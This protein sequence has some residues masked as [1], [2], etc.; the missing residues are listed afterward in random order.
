MEQYTK[1]LADTLYTGEERNDRT[2]VGTIGTFSRSLSFDLRDGYPLVTTKKV[3]YRAVFAEL[4]GFIE[5][6]TS[7]ARFRE[8]GTKIWDQN[9]NENEAWLSNPYRRGTDDLGP[10]YGAQ[11]RNWIANDD[12]RTYSVIDQ[13]QNLIDG[14]LADPYDRAHIVS[15]WNPAVHDR[16]ALRPCHVMFQCYVGNE[17]F[18]DMA[19]VMRSV[20]LF[21]G[22][23]FNI[24]SYAALLHLIA[25]LTNLKP[26]HL[27]YQLGDCHIYKNH[28]DQVVEQIARKPMALPEL[29]VAN[30]ADLSEV[31]PDIFQ[32]HGYESHP[33]I[34][35]P[36][37]V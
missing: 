12:G 17:G 23:P 7:A 3:N 10:I 35:A 34:F 29:T 30:I 37:A 8:L 16:V 1:L 11:W 19:V 6:A 27:T 20:D 5:G 21:L 22:L 32:V 18:L 36:M 31:T 26:R 25:K 28:V 14:I 13:L 24:A 4:A 2:G 15:G 9:A 33:A